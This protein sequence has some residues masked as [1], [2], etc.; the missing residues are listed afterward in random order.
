MISSPDLKDFLAKTRDMKFGVKSPRVH[1]QPSD[2]QPDSEFQP[3]SSKLT[4][5]S[6]HTT[7][8][9]CI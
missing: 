2:F 5:S 4:P 3:E 6:S 9:R 8:K 7:Y 1:Q